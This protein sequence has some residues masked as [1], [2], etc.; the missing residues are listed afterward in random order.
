MYEWIIEIVPSTSP[1]PQAVTR[2]MAPQGTND[3]AAFSNRGKRGISADLHCTS[4]TAGKD[5]AAFFLIHGAWHGGWCWEEVAPLL[6]A[7]GHSV[8]TPDLPGMGADRT[9]FADDVVAQ[10]TDALTALI[11]ARSEPVVLVGHS[12]AGILVSSL[13]ERL[14]ER[15]RLGIYLAAVMVLNQHSMFD[16]GVRS[17]SIEAAMRL[18]E[19]TGLLT[20]DPIAALPVFYGD[21]A[22]DIAGRAAARLCAEPFRVF[23]TPLHLTSERYGRVP[24]AYI[25]TTDDQAIPLAE[26]RSMQSRVPCESVVS[27][28]GGHSPFYGMPARLAEVLSDLVMPRG[29]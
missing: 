2:G 12:R 9:P 8:F 26:Q 16:M 27:L 24:R 13:S 20:L 6:E 7:H 23:T 1:V 14:P 18:D 19:A 4:D 5:V 28:P 11:E 22:A 15:I 3:A 25:E 10:W 29:A 17:S 21:I